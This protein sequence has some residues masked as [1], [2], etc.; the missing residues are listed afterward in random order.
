M[1]LLKT[2]NA[3]NIFSHHII[4]STTEVE[5]LIWFQVFLVPRK[6]GTTNVELNV[7]RHN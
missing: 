7:A 5:K 1:L 6:L 4:V 3:A 2:M